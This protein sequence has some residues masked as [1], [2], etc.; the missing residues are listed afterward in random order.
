MNKGEDR[1]KKGF[2]KGILLLLATVF[3]AAMLTACGKEK[4]D[5]NRF[6]VKL[7]YGYGDALRLDSYAPFYIDVTNYGKDFSGTVQLIIPN[8][9]G[10]IL[11]E[12]EISIPSGA[13][14]SVTMTG[15]IV[16]TIH[17]VNIRLGKDRDHII[18]KKLFLVDVVS[19]NEDINIGILS[20]DYTALGYMDRRTFPLYPS[21]KTRIFELNADT[22]PDDAHALDM[23]DM[24]VVSDF[25]TDIL[26]DNQIS[27]L[28]L[29]NSEGGVLIV[30]TGS[31]YNKTLSK[32]NHDFFDAEPGELKK[33]S[34]KFGLS[35]RQ[36]LSTLPQE[37]YENQSPYGNVEYE[38]AY[39]EIFQNE[40]ALLEEEYLEKFLEY[41]DHT[42]E[43]YCNDTEGDIKDEFYWYCFEEF[44]YEFY[45]YGMYLEE[46]ENETKKQE[47]LP[48]VE[49]DV[50]ELTVNS[51]VIYPN[52]EAEIENRSE[53]FPLGY[54]LP[55]GSGYVFLAT[56][57]FTK[58]PL[59]RY[60]GNEDMFMY[61]AQDILGGTEILS[62]SN[63][64]VYADNL[65]RNLVNM[66]KGAQVPPSLVY[67]IL[68]LAYLIAIIVCYVVF[69]K[70]R[71]TTRLW[72]VYP[73]MSLAFAILI[74]CVGFSTRLL[75]PY[76]N[77]VSV[78]ELQDTVA[79]RTSVMGIIVPNDNRYEVSLSKDYA[80]SNNVRED[81]YYYW[82]EADCD[83]DKYTSSFA[84]GL[85][86]N[87]IL[88]ENEGAL[89]CRNILLK[90]SYRTD[91]SVEI[92]H[93]GSDVYEVT[94]HY[95]CDLEAAYIYADGKL[96]YIGEL[97]NGETCIA[98]EYESM[99]IYRILDKVEE[100]YG[101]DHLLGMFSGLAIGS[102]S[103]QYNAYQRGMQG[104]AAGEKYIRMA[105]SL[106]YSRY[107]TDLQNSAQR[108]FVA[109]PSKT[110]KGIYQENSKYRENCAEVICMMQDNSITK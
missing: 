95:G 8:T 53:T 63:G 102:L 14:K 5:M 52:F 4:I 60:E 96:F 39:D 25:S 15:E 46:F 2:K 80:I 28:R 86:D 61:I 98:T 23:L 21:Y 82:D 41:Y 31:T 1:M 110:E 54:T 109:I 40:Q 108:V 9:N 66:T 22:F 30:G 45:L 101:G 12:K 56:V 99:P 72:I 38:S 94:N 71:K 75:R 105:D 48:Y 13:T 103:P 91:Q 92:K 55:M 47:E 93:T 10:N 24:I 43:D 3:F 85:D 34:T 79:S 26:T 7:K 11:Y 44:F 90:N 16:N 20:D 84:S 78:I 18:W 32:L 50:L 29:W 106:C 6:E 83:Y 100:K 37:I 64:E 104:I 97:E 36:E 57:D 73:I 67:I 58:N 62:G 42:Y 70:K 88:I 107:S 81:Y 19:E 89:S 17:N 35:L 33:Y 68:F 69:S 77:V 27:A 49:A 51:V 65:A 76:I 87:R 74:Y 59:S